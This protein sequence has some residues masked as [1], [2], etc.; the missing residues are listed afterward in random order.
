V[1]SFFWGRAQAC[2]GPLQSPAGE[3]GSAAH[4]LAPERRYLP[5]TVCVD[6]GNLR[7]AVPRSQGQGRGPT[8]NCFLVLCSVG[9]TPLLVCEARVLAR[10]RR[11]A[12]DKGEAS[13]TGQSSLGNVLMAA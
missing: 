3:R 7:C 2:S 10:R 6:G 12:R 4:G 11:R 5:H 9:R 8:Q 13:V 1:W